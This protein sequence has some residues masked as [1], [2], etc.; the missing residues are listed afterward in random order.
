[1]ARACVVRD[2]LVE[3]RSRSLDQGLDALV[4][5]FDQAEPALAQ[6]VC[7]AAQAALLEGP[8]RTDD[9]CL[10]AVRME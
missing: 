8:T 6:E 7:A 9:V 10:L 5:V 3:N 1:M 2:G 4:A